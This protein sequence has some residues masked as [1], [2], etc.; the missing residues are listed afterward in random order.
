MLC[1]LLIGFNT[2]SF[3]LEN[4]IFV[5]CWKQIIIP[6]SWNWTH[7]QFS[8]QCSNGCQ[9]VLCNFQWLLFSIMS[10]YCTLLRGGTLFFGTQCIIFIY[11]L[12]HSSYGMSDSKHNNWL[13]DTYTNE[14]CHRILTMSL[15]KYEVQCHIWCTKL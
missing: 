5:C 12:L 13:C 4:C 3:V 2:D 7:L 8:T 9:F 15:N 6:W 11:Y 10:V 1:R 14:L